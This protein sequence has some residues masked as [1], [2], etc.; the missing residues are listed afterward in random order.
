MQWGAYKARMKDNRLSKRPIKY[1][2]QGRRNAG[3]PES[4]WLDQ[5]VWTGPSCLNLNSAEKM[6]A[7]LVE[8]VII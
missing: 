3:I 5:Q 6:K 8:E 2:P 4:R 1:R 7:V